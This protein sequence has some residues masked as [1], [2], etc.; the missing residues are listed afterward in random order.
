[1]FK[2]LLVFV[3]L[4]GWSQQDCV[5][6]QDCQGTGNKPGSCWPKPVPEAN[7]KPKIL[8]DEKLKA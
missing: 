5:I 2:I 4:F 1:M 6:W 3:A 7:K 8:P